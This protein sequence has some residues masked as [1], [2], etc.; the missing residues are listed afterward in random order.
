MHFYLYYHLQSPSFSPHKQIFGLFIEEHT[1]TH[2]YLEYLSDNN[3]ISSQHIGCV[4]VVFN[5]VV[6]TQQY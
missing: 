3:I 2:M 4:C 5:Y 1:Q 6:D